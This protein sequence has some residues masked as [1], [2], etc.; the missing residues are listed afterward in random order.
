[1]IKFTLSTSNADDLD[2]GIVAMHRLVSYQYFPAQ[3]LSNTE[4]V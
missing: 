3:I 1:M 2:I 4:F